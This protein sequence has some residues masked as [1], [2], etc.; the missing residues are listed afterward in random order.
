[1][2]SEN[3][4]RDLR[5]VGIEVEGRTSESLRDVLIARLASVHPDKTGGEFHDEAQADSFRK[6]KDLLERLDAQGTVSSQLIPIQHIV[7]I[8]DVLS[9]LQ[10]TNTTAPEQKQLDVS[11]R[12]K[13]HLRRKYALPKITSALVAGL[14]FAL[15][16]LLGNFR[17]NPLYRASVDVYAEDSQANVV[18]WAKSRTDVLEGRLEGLSDRTS[19]AD[20][21]I[22]RLRE[23]GRTKEPVAYNFSSTLEDRYRHEDS[24]RDPRPEDKQ[25]L[26]ES[27]ELS[28]SLFETTEPDFLRNVKLHSTELGKYVGASLTTLAGINSKEVAQKNRKEELNIFLQDTQSSIA[29]FDSS[30]KSAEDQLARQKAWA[31]IYADKRILRRLAILMVLACSV[32][33]LLW[34]RERSDER[35]VEFLSTDEGVES[36]LSRLSVNSNIMA[37]NPPGFSLSEFTK[38]VGTKDVPLILA[39]VIGARLDVKRLG[40]VSTLILEK[41]KSKNVVSE[42]RTSA[43]Q[44][45]FEVQVGTDIVSTKQT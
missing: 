2:Y 31:I 28:V 40:E 13:K 27:S 6:I 15:F 18:K 5:E 44:T 33:A 45:W 39:P 30:V 21:E 9:K 36:V 26:E 43:L 25:S 41:L 23:S 12:Y 34:A 29:A 20:A 16:S 42:R 22:S 32:F 14:C 1:M 10:A 24:N 35:W 7:A 4:K 38:I 19:F 17:Q 37:R 3:L 8:V 11:A